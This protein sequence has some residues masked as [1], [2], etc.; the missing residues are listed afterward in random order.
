MKSAMQNIADFPYLVVEHK[1]IATADKHHPV[2]PLD[3][4]HDHHERIERWI[5][6]QANVVVGNRDIT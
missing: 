3:L 6:E 5:L 4:L 1:P 2:R